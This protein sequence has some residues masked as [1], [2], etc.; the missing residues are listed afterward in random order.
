MP[1]TITANSKNTYGRLSEYANPLLIAEEKQAYGR[2]I[3]D[4]H[5]STD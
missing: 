5:V 3:E 1:F 2:V 4:K